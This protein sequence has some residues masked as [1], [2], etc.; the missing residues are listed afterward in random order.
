MNGSLQQPFQYLDLFDTIYLLITKKEKCIMCMTLKNFHIEQTYMFQ[1]NYT[2]K[3][4]RK[5]ENKTFLPFKKSLKY[6]FL[7]HGNKSMIQ[8]SI[9]RN[10]CF[11]LK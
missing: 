3:F 10:K 5:E 8:Q 2:G 11:P 4:T 9:W 6:S 7:Y 1:R